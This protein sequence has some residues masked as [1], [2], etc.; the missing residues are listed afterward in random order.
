MLLAFLASLAMA[1]QQQARVYR[2]GG[3]WAQDITGS[4]ATA[5]NLSV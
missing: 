3:N 4:L 2:D 1:Q 5:K